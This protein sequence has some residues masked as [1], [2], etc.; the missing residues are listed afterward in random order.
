MSVAGVAALLAA[1]P[2][3]QPDTASVMRIALAVLEVCQ[4]ME[5]AY[6][7]LARSFWIC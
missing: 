1:E 7:F 5:M 6:H 2:V 3:G 4:H